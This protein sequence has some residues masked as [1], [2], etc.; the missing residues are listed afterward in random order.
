MK[1][2]LAI[3]V[4]IIMSICMMACS[5]DKN[6]TDNNQNV[7]EAVTAAPVSN[8]TNQSAQTT[9]DLTPAPAVTEAP[10]VTPEPED[11]AVKAIGLSL[12]GDTIC[13]WEDDY[14]STKYYVQY[15]TVFVSNDYA[16]K[17]PELSEALLQFSEAAEQGA[18]GTADWLSEIYEEEKEFRQQE[19]AEGYDYYI[20][21][22]DE[23]SYEVVRADS[24][25]VCLND[26]YSSYTGGAHGNYGVYGTTF[27]S[28]TGQVLNIG[29]I[30]TDMDKLADAIVE[31]LNEN[32]PDTWFFVDDDLRTDIMTR[33][34]EGRLNFTLGYDGV[35]ISFNPY[36]I[37][38]YADGILFAPLTFAEYP[39]LFNEKYTKAP[40]SYMI[41]MVGMYAE[42]G[43]TSSQGDSKVV[44]VI[45]AYASEEDMYSSI[46]EYEGIKVVCGNS[47]EGE[48]YIE[49]YG[50]DIESSFVVTPS[51]EYLL[52]ESTGASDVTTIY[53]VAL[54]DKPEVLQRFTFSN[55]DGEWVDGFDIEKYAETVIY[56]P[57]NIVLS[58]RIDILGTN[59]W[60]AH[61][62]MDDTGM[63]IRTDDYYTMRYPLSLTLKSNLSVPEVDFE[64]GELTGK[65]IELVKGCE[66]E[67][68]RTDG[69]YDVDCVITGSDDYFRLQI[70][71]YPSPYDPDEWIMN[72]YYQNIDFDTLFDGILYA[73]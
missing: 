12:C 8:E 31:K 66:I 49:D 61:Y 11:D 53:V 14:E 10:V 1:R 35:T 4:C 54:G 72:R 13:E 62:A 60:R 17:Y 71:G 32:Y 19:A 40:E 42:L 21:I 64:T 3:V 41:N 6:Q 70:G 16:S 51:G 55:I 29:D 27:D 43:Y 59:F 28:Q 5:K 2:R 36:E 45:P 23:S 18:Y 50:W 48:L 33:V 30:V 22:Y 58:H 44:S 52:I 67:V 47:A 65:F 68:I 46:S 34:D 25:A 69:M 63:L 39:E 24:V 57:E 38:S 73:G 20:D 26:H 7:T 37:A 15:Q 56:T 9:D